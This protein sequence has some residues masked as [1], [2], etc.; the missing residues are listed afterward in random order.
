METTRTRAHTHTLASVKMENLANGTFI[1][2]I[3]SFT[4]T[5]VAPG[6]L[7]IISSVS[8]EVYDGPSEF[9]KDYICKS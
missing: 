2:L 8:M 5:T 6:N 7:N 1:T 9:Q 4:D 3:V